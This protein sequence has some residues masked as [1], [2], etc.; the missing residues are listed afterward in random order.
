MTHRQHF[1]IAGI[2]L[3]LATKAGAF[4]FEFARATSSA[5][6]FS[7]VLPKPFSEL[8]ANAGVN[9]AA[10]IKPKQSFVIGGKPAPRVVFIATKMVYGSTSD[11]RSVVTS[12]S[13]GEPPGFRRAY[14]KKV[15]VAGLPGLEIKSLSPSTV[16]YRRVL[17]AGDT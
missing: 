15:Q 13:G 6:Q 11:A 10:A 3:L 16:G 5:G 8:P 9:S 7:V 14:I 12:I 17:L 4:D 1:A 2:F